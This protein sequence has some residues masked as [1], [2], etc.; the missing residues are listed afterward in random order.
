MSK[1]YAVIRT[2]GEVSLEDCI[3]ALKNQGFTEYR[4]V[5]DL[6]LQNATKEILRIGYEKDQE[7]DWIMVVDADIILTVSKEEIEEYCNGIPKQDKLFCFTGWLFGTK[8]GYRDGMHF[9]RT[10]YCKEALNLI[11]YLDFSWHKGR[12]E[13]EICN[14]VKNNSTLVWRPGYKDYKKVC[15]GIHLANINKG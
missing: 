13:S 10:K 9:Y 2:I 14:Y 7:Y 5:K 3:G 12:E 15:F 6:T 11:K 1:V 8:I 4:I